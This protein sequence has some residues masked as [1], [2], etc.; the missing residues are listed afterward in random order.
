MTAAMAL[1][2]I[3]CHANERISEGAALMRQIR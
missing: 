3:A 1:K 2:P